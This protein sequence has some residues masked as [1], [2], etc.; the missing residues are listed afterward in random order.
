[1]VFKL[2][3]ISVVKTII[4]VTMVKTI[5]NVTIGFDLITKIYFNS[6]IINSS[7]NFIIHYLLNSFKLSNYIIN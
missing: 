7:K 6:I 2:F 3:V 4:N 1:M 5:I